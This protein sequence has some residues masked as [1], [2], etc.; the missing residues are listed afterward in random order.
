MKK[1]EWTITTLKKLFITL[2]KADNRRA[3]KRFHIYAKGAESRFVAQEKVRAADVLRTDERFTA[4]DRA[5]TTAFTTAEKAAAKLETETR[6]WKASANEWRN[7]LKDRDQTFWSRAQ[8]E[9]LVRALAERID[10]VERRQDRS[11]GRGV[12]LNQGWIYLIAG[13]GLISTL[14]LMAAAIYTI[15]KH[16]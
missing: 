11:E 9:Q 10:A 2:R 5:I 8:G 16:N 15:L 4:L 1:T 7:T 3:T 12:G 13:V 14:V 6:E